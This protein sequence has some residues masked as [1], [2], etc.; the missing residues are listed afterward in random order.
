M[1]RSAG[2]TVLD[3]IRAARAPLCAAAFAVSLTPA[4]AQSD[5]G[6]VSLEYGPVP[7]VEGEDGMFFRLDPDL[8]MD[9]RFSDGLVAGI[10]RLSQA[11]AAHGTRL[12]YVPVPTK[13]MVMPD[14][15]G[16]DA[17]RFAYDVRLARALYS[18]NVS[19][20]R[21]AGVT[22]VD[23][24]TPLIVSADDEAVFFGPDPRMTPEGMMRLARAVGAELGPAFAR[25]ETITIEPT[26]E[27]EL[28][29]ETRRLLQ[30]S[31]QAD[32]PEIRTRTFA[33][34]L[35]PVWDDRAQPRPIAVIGS[36][37]TGGPKRDFAAFV[38]ETMQRRNVRS[39]ATEDAVAALAGYLT[40][41]AFRDEA[42]EALVWQVPVWT[43]S[44]LFG[45]QPMGEL[46]AA[47]ADDCGAPV[48][49][50]VLGDGAYEV[51]L[52]AGASD[53]GTLR[54]DTGERA[55]TEAVFHFA[56]VTGGERVRSVVRQDPAAATSRVFLPM[57]GLWPEGAVSVS[58]R[59]DAPLAAPPTV[60]VCRG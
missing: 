48:A 31:C 20:L 29:S 18:D 9:H 28:P 42:P 10:A 60:S 39:L 56:S 33:L 4:H 1:P 45:D 53:G 12:V 5:H 36:H 16:P 7:S 51:T 23:A 59:L 52:A 6:C 44:A 30:L 8:V 58:V 11:L 25:D 55:V 47:A 57:T 2:A 21:A 27:T 15:L 19:A 13:A 41:D 32:L 50:R 17:E 37:I 43:N 22:T 34:H 46:I 26:G 14:R 54:L 38:S 24:L 35:D 49:A 3:W 40:S